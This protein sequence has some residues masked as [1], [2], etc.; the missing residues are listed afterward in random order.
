[1]SSQKLEQ[2]LIQGLQ[3]I[4]STAT[5]LYERV[6]SAT[7][8]QLEDSKISNL[9]TNITKVTSQCL[10]FSKKID[11]GEINTSIHKPLDE[12]LVQQMFDTKIT[13]M[14]LIQLFQDNPNI[15]IGSNSQKE[16]NKLL[17]SLNSLYSGISAYQ[18]KI[19]LATGEKPRTSSIVHFEGGG[20]RKFS[21][22]KRSK[23]SK[24]RIRRSKKTKRSKS[25]K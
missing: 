9:K 3:N 21:K 15:I 14:H 5:T 18:T 2:Q 23:K 12:S 6:T 22:F 7:P 8:Q 4:W 17:E 11:G 19:T 24:R 20:K 13:V 25:K 1:M 10:E 16:K